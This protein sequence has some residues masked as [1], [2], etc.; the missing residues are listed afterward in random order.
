ML[1]AVIEIM[2]FVRN[3]F[4]CAEQFPQMFKFI[5]TDSYCC[6]VQLFRYANNS[7]SPAVQGHPL[8]G[9]SKFVQN[10]ARRLI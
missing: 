8:V 5:C 7:V 2:V 6:I 1:Q 3:S 4:V 10:L 9:M